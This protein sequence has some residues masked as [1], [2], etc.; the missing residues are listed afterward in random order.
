[1]RVLGNEL[2]L[3]N[4]EYLNPSDVAAALEEEIGDARALSPADTQYKGSFA[5][6]PRAAQVDYAALDVPIYAID[7][8]V[9][10]SE[11]LQ[12]TVLGRA[13]QGAAA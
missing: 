4:C 12:E 10:R 2:E 8:L 13:G 9:R 3:P 6:S 5:P 11:P 7:A 1:L